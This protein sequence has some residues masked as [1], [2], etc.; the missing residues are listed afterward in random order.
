[1]HPPRE[2]VRISGCLPVPSMPLLRDTGDQYEELVLDT[3][4]PFDD[5]DHWV[6]HNIV[7][8]LPK[9]DEPPKPSCWPAEWNKE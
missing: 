4:E 3:A 5:I 2:A 6:E 7:N 9:L 8:G 1:M